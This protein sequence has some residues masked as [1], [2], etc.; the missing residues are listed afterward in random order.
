MLGGVGATTTGALEAL[1]LAVVVLAVLG[2]GVAVPAVVVCA[3][4]IDRSADAPQT[5]LLVHVGLP[6][7]GSKQ[8]VSVPGQAILIRRRAIGAAFLDLS[9]I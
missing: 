6:V 7:S 5:P 4:G 2:V 3:V 8:Y 1:R 9:S